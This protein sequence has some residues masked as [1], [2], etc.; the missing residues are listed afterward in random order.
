M[1]WYDYTKWVLDRVDGFPKNQRFVLGT[2]L[3][4]AVVRVLELLGEAARFAEGGCR[5]RPCRA[6]EPLDVPA[7]GFPRGLRRIS[8][9][10]AAVS[11]F[12]SENRGGVMLQ[13]VGTNRWIGW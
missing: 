13:Q 2:R 5:S 9:G 10:S 7:G 12:T 3:A 8:P 1:K 6:Q 11:S 4:D